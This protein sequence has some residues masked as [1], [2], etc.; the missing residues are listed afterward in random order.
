MDLPPASQSSLR[1]RLT[2]T[3]TSV[4]AAILLSVTSLF[5]LIGLRSNEALLAER[6]AEVSE[7]S[8]RSLSSMLWKY[9]DDS[10]VEFV[11]S[12][13]LFEDVIFV[14]V[15]GDNRLVYQRRRPGSGEQSPADLEASPWHLATQSEITHA[16]TRVGSVLIV[17]S[18][19]RYLL[20][21]RNQATIGILVAILT[22]LGL[23]IAIQ[24]MMRRHVFAPLAKLESS[25][26]EVAEG[27]LNV[28]IEVCGEGEIASL[29]RAFDTMLKRLAT[30]TASRDEL[31][32]AVLA[33]R[34]SEE[35][36]EKLLEQLQQASKMEAVGRLAGGVAHDFNNILAAILGYADLIGETFAP[37]DE[38]RRDI[39]RIVEA[40][41]SA[42]TL[43][44]QLL[45][46]SRKQLI[47][48]RP[49]DLNAT[50]TSSWNML[51]RLIGED[52]ALEFLP[53]PDLGFVRMDPTQVDQILLNLVVNARDAIQD[54]GSVVVETATTTMT[55]QMCQLCAEPMEGDFVVLRVRDDGAGMDPDTQAKIFEPFYTTKEMGRGTGLGLAMVHGI[56]HQNRGHIVVRSEPGSGTTFEIYLPRIREAP[57]EE[58]PHGA[59]AY[60]YPGS[61]TILVA[62]D[63]PEVRDM[64]RRILEGQGYRV[65]TA[66]DG[67]AAL[68]VARGFDGRIDLLLTDVIMPRRNG[69]DL[70]E[71]LL[72]ERPETKVVFMSG[73]PENKLPGEHQAREQLHFLSKPIRAGALRAKIEEALG[74]T[75]P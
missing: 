43:V 37:E 32:R 73:Y 19:Q 45:A 2:R 33:H 46:F 16:G 50:V 74:G 22:I 11:E 27:D 59:L 12:L 42:A 7:Q 34:Q 15:N 51:E 58:A 48:A 41:E 61:A 14:R 71:Q 4:V 53:G 52:V 20:L 38:R 8:C 18:R 29:A 6:L 1:R 66:E 63:Q 68:E 35:E 55:E 67:E 40:T 3:L 60:S 47:S 36:R 70:Q 10:V 56:A 39:Q 9:D 17:V 25:T 31:N 23:S 30:I 65:L 24:V 57:D 62:E 72:E 49:I 44:Q 75:S 21:F 54:H 64:T 26:A 28:E 13:F 69:W 5:L